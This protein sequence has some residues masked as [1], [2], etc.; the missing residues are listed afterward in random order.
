MKKGQSVLEYAILIV[1]AVSAL[2]AMQFYIQRGMQGKLKESADE[3]SAGSQYAPTKTTSSITH[4]VESDTTTDVVTEL[5]TLNGTI[6]PSDAT[7]VKTTST[8]T[9][10]NE[11]DTTK[12]TE[13]VEKWGTSLYEN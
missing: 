6:D 5:D 13:N 10:N 12:G 8:T 2:I 7:K 4:T 3:I 11:T 9:I 1:A